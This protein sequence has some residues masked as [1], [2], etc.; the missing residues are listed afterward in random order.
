MRSVIKKGWFRGAIG[1]GFLAISFLGFYSYFYLPAPFGWFHDIVLG[2]PFVL[3]LVLTNRGLDNAPNPIFSVMFI[4][5]FWGIVGLLFG[6]I[7]DFVKAR[8]DRFIRSE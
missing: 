7:R 6:A 5:T 3:L 8:R 2:M 1:G 4:V